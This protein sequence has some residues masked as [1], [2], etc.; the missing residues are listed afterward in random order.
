MIAPRP[1]LPA[2]LDFR[3]IAVPFLFPE[4]WCFLKKAQD[5]QEAHGRNNLY[6]SSKQLTVGPKAVKAAIQGWECPAPT[7]DANGK[8][9]WSAAHLP[10]SNIAGSHSSSSS[11]TFS[12]WLKER[13]PPGSTYQGEVGTVLPKGWHANTPGMENLQVP[14]MQ[15]GAQC[16]PRRLVWCSAPRG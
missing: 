8:R 1:P 13:M 11:S 6:S 2:K 5:M 16:T 9:S 7:S 14:C 10:S 12:S 15:L 3:F 4:E